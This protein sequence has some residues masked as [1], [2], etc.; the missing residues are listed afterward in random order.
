MTSQILR[1]ARNY[2]EEME[3]RISEEERPAFHLSARVGWMNDPNGFC[4][5]KGEYHLFYQYHPFD[6]CWGPMHWGHA[7]SR[8]LLHWRYLPA[9]FAPDTEYDRDGCFSGS[10]IELPDGKHLLM[11][12]GV[13]METQPDGSQREVQTQCLAVGD[14][15]DYEKYAENPVLDEKDVPENGSRHDFRDPR[16]WRKQDGTYCCV[17]GNRRGEK[18]GQILLFTS[19]DA[20][21]WE[22][23]KC[24]AVNYERYG[25]MWECPDFFAL[26]KKQVLLVSPQEMMP[27]DLEYPN[28][29]GTVCL[30]GTY[31][32][33]T[34]EF[35]EE[36]DQSIDYGIDFYA[37]QTVLAPDGRRIMIGW[38]QNWDTC[39][40]HGTGRA[41][42]GQMSLPREL[43]VKNGRL[44]QNPVRELEEMRGEK[45]SYENVCFSE[46][47]SLDGVKGRKVDMELTLRPGNE[48]EMYRKFAVHF[49]QD[50]T[51]HTA[52]SFRPYESVVKVD[53]K[54]S[55]SRKSTIHERCCFV[56]GGNGHIKLRVILDRFSAE[57]FVNDGE[58]A[59]SLTFYTDIAADGI[60]F[61][62]DG[63]VA[64][65]V[66]K[67]DL[68]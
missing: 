39:S 15:A 47:I 37:P 29:N 9:A 48:Q 35:T 46:T 36:R 66:V 13:R 64:M 20:F 68:I 22:F 44:F 11:Y 17:A 10:A 32:E 6:T 63:D 62:A 61:F 52:V 56:P 59:L 14:G 1:D 21:H 12:T 16:I 60:S 40:L 58:Y 33:E 24:L 25:R 42:F 31:D 30:I 55:G 57:I 43:R 65:D 3:K 54:Y 45:I 38:M 49:A 18:D 53:R 34:E 7:V 8:D 2:E 41:W 23:R 4:F 19:P 28:G 50:D 26:D 51:C 67:Y 27:R 5:Y